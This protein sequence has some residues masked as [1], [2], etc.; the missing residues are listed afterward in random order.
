MMRGEPVAEGCVNFPFHSKEYDGT[1]G[2]GLVVKLVVLD[3]PEGG[4][5]CSVYVADVLNN[6][7]IGDDKRPQPEDTPLL[8]EEPE[9]IERQMIAEQDAHNDWVGFHYPRHDA[10]DKTEA[11]WL[12][13]AYRA[14]IVLGS[15]GWAGY[16]EVHG[17]W[18]AK[19]ED[20]TSEGQE[21]YR[22]MERMN[23]DCAVH[24]LTFLD[25]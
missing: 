25:T 12:S 18:Y 9:A 22:L 14:S 17:N 8:T 3:R 19:F 5:C 13:R 6:I 7:L 4:M 20:L 16:S 11:D 2:R 15:T 10:K 1:A 24:I 21:L 23:P